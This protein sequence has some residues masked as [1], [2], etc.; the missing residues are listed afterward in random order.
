MRRAS[1]LIFILLICIPAI[2]RI[3]PEHPA[4]WIW[5]PG[6]N[7]V[8]C[9]MRFRKQVTID[10]LPAKMQ[11]TIAADSKYW[12]WIN[13]Q[14]IIREGGLKRTPNPHDTY[15]D[16]ID[17][18]P[19]LVKG[20]NT[21][22]A[23]VWYWGKEG[24]GHNS[25]G[26]GGFYLNTP[27]NSLI[28]TDSSWRASIHP[29]FDTLQTGPQPYR[30]L[31]E[32]N[33]TFDARKDD[34][35]WYAAD[36]DD[37]A[38]P[39]AANYGTSPALPWGKLVNRQIPQW[40]DYG[41]KNYVN[42]FSKSPIGNIM[43]MKLPYN[44][45]ITPYFKIKAPAGLVININTDKYTDG[46]AY[47]VRSCYITRSGVQEFESPG[48][49]SGEQVWYTFPTGVEV[50]SL[51]YR[52][53]GYD[54]GFDG[55]FTCNDEFYNNLWQKARRTLYL[56]MRDNFMDCP[57]RERAM[58]WGDV[59]TESLQGY[60]AFSASAHQ[61]VQKAINELVSWQTDEGVLYSPIPG[62]HP[63]LPFGPHR[64]LPLQSLAA[65]GNLGFW[66]YYLFT[67]DK[68]TLIEAYPT[69]KKYL[70][71]WS[72]GADGL[73]KHRDGKWNWQDW[74]QNIDA[75]LLDNAW[76]YSALSSAKKMAVLSGFP[77]DTVA[78][79][80]Q[81]ISISAKFDQTFWTGT[82]Y[83]SPA[84]KGSPDDRGNAMA[85]VTGLAGRDKWEQINEVL[86][87]QQ[88]AGP[89]M[90]KYVLEAMFMMGHADDALQRMKERYAAM[91]NGE[92]TTLWEGWQ[93]GFYETSNH[94]WSGGPL[95][96]LMQYAAGIAP[97]EP[98]FK[99]FMIK[100][101][102][103]G[104]KHIN[105]T[106]PTRYGLINFDLVPDGALL[107]IKLKVPAGTQGLLDLSG[108]DVSGKL[109]YIN[110]GL[111]GSQL[112]KRPGQIKVFYKDGHPVYVFNGE[113]EK[114]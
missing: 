107:N 20:K 58:W 41:L 48:W 54:T 110:G 26:R 94:G 47:N 22:A 16:T 91:V 71:L 83:R 39:R 111:I 67:G 18:K 68:K 73:V 7:Q 52:E 96:L 62:P 78:Y 81:M 46:G 74:G 65:I 44:A 53:T 109:L 6:I 93:Q 21:I 66:D 98:G 114:N 90:E 104:L 75:P 51:Q 37:C 33:V 49:M 85:V 82:A 102:P 103:G 11:T 9:W 64:E 25:S 76:Y 92:G 55:A 32:F 24:H 29:G 30:P 34:T 36:Y 79:Q 88:Y 31:A 72:I 2:A 14:L 27:A 89:Y 100:P 61:L 4:Q 42:S 57:T 69:V 97:V 5:Q 8:N 86:K 13:G 95:A 112:L 70:S 19:Y 1:L 80:T 17:L 28:A 106:V 63:P 45:Q 105:A 43:I 59:V 113:K 12:L 77:K 87:N 84:H 50:I 99:K 108:I 23:L 38:W 56:N 15:A 60:Y 101:L 35:G 40:K 10:Q 3:A